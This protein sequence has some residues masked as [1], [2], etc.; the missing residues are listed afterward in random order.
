MPFYAVSKNVADNWGVLSKLCIAN[1]EATISTL[2]GQVF[3]R[4]IGVVK[5]RVWHP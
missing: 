5:P 1:K 3:W 4:D 2:S